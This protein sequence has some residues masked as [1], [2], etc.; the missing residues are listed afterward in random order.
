M[1]PPPRRANVDTMCIL[2]YRDVT[3][4]KGSCSPLF[5]R[6]YGRVG[7]LLLLHLQPCIHPHGHW[8]LAI[9]HADQHPDV[10]KRPAL[11]LTSP[12]PIFKKMYSSLHLVDASKWWALHA[13]ECK[14]STMLFDINLSYFLGNRIVLRKKYEENRRMNEMRTWNNSQLLRGMTRN[15]IRLAQNLWDLDSLSS[16]IRRIRDESVITRKFWK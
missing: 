6:Y 13:Y 14:Y 10:F 5:R 8:L 12:G 7:L 16:H 11:N 3:M 15:V 1:R 4:Q 2:L 9:W